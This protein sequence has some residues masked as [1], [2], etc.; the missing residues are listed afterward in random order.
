MDKCCNNY[1][2]GT[3]YLIKNNGYFSIIC[4][5]FNRPLNHGMHIYKESRFKPVIYESSLGG[6]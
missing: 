1:N 2:C 3:Y 6:D 4:A 5:I